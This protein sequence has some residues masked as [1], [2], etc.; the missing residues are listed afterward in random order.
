M[1]NFDSLA[2]AAAARII[3][4]A[5]KKKVKMSDLDNQ[6]TTAMNILTEQG[7]Y[8][9]CL[10]LKEKKYEHIASP[11]NNFFKEPQNPLYLKNNLPGHEACLELTSSLKSM[12]LARQLI[13]LILTYARHMAKAEKG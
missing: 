5:D 9:M 1:I 4:A 12:F 6:V 7:I 8:A 3:F 10:W 2:V 13:E 11:L